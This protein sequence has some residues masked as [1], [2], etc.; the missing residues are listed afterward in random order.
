VRTHHHYWASCG[1]PGRSVGPG[2]FFS[3]LTV[4][5]LVMLLIALFTLVP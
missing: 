1:E 4:V 5:L 2:E 3:S